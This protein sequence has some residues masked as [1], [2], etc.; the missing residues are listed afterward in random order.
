M[1]L[2][3]LSMFLKITKTNGPQR[4]FLSTIL[5]NFKSVQVYISFQLTRSMIC[6][7]V[8]RRMMPE[9]FWSVPASLGSLSLEDKRTESLHHINKR[10][11]QQETQAVPQL[12][13]FV[14]CSCRL[15]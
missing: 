14:A 10:E 1:L 6:L 4:H 7:I 5:H 3:F 13:I 9:L 2:A 11:R 8:C 12:D 15:P